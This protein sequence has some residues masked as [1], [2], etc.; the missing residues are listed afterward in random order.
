MQWLW[1]PNSAGGDLT[2]GFKSHDLLLLWSSETTWQTKTIIPPPPQ[3]TTKLGSLVAYF[4]GF[5]TIKSPYNAFITC[6]ARLSDK[7]K[8]LY[9][10]LCYQNA[11]AHQNWQDGNLP[12]QAPTHYIFT[13]TGPMA[14]KLGRM[15]AYL[16]Q[17]LPIKLL[18]PLVTC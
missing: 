10:C 16:K 13:T 2:W 8:P 7:W 15:V 1:P 4:E 6:L 11:C 3:L 14:T 18:D 9:L 12:W 17:L 5:L